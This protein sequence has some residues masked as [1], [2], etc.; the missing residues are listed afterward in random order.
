MIRR[1]LMSAMVF[2]GVLAMT[3]LPT[4]LHGEEAHAPAPA[5][6]VSAGSASAVESVPT[7][8]VSP[9]GACVAGNAALEDLRRQRE[10]LAERERELA[11]KEN[12]LKALERAV[13]EQFAKLDETRGAIARMEGLKKKENEEKVAKV[14]ETIE[15]MSPKS[16]AQML[17]GLDDA[18]AVTAMQRMS[19]PKLAKIMNL[20]EPGR[21]S[22]LTEL[23]A[24]VVTGGAG[25]A[26]RARGDRAASNGAVVA[27]LSSKGGEKHDE[28]YDQSNVSGGSN[29]TA[30]VG[31]PKTAGI[32]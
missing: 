19:T 23:L 22:R 25:S 5:S 2:S 9:D 7:A 13:Q 15:T 31:A 1:R 30:S 28:H 3:A 16:A 17:A 27:T 18:L 11:A 4:V 21:S 32:R 12:E 6:P 26:A 20:M 14:V 24:G 8:A 29:G 10:R